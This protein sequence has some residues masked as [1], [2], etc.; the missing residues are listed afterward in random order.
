[1]LYFR[2]AVAGQWTVKILP[3]ALDALRYPADVS[4]SFSK[5]P[6]PCSPRIQSPVLDWNLTVNKAVQAYPRGCYYRP[7]HPFREGC[8]LAKK[9]SS[10]SPWQWQ[11][12][13]FLNGSSVSINGRGRR[14]DSREESQREEGQ[15]LRKSKHPNCLPHRGPV[16]NQGHREFRFFPSMIQRKSPEAPP[17]ERREAERQEACPFP[18]VAPGSRPPARSTAPPAIGRRGL[19]STP[20]RYREE[21][22]R[23]A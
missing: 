6:F 4:T 15:S 14:V 9:R 11:Q 18:R 21:P 10:I 3:F 1:M 19:T 22:S 2:W 23:C 16:G 17:A 5:M 20:R 12:P 8:R 13:S 7:F